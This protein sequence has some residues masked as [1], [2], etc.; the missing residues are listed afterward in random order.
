LV[1]ASCIPRILTAKRVHS[2]NAYLAGTA[3]ASRSLQC[4]AANYLA[5]AF[6]ATEI[7]GALSA[8]TTAAIGATV[9][10]FALGLAN[11]TFPAYALLTITTWRVTGGTFNGKEARGIGA[12]VGATI[13]ERTLPT[14]GGAQSRA[15]D[16]VDLP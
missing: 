14:A 12:P 6:L 3:T 2:A 4:I 16:A 5:E 13:I 9:L 8:L 1:G 7:L 10:A 11:D 15:I